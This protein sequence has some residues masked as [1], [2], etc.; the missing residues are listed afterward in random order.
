M[1]H[2]GCWLGTSKQSYAWSGS[3]WQPGEGDG[4]LTLAGAANT[5]A[6]VKRALAA[7]KHQGLV[8]VDD[9]FDD[10]ALDWRNLGATSWL[11]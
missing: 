4:A 11:T 1:T 9:S 3:S 2:A 10:P 7:G 5:L 8:D 6:A